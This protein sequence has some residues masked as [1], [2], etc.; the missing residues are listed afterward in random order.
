MEF[1][2]VHIEVI[3][4]VAVLK[5]FDPPANTLTYDLVQQL[6][7]AY[8]EILHQPQVNAVL[9]TGYGDRFFSGGVNIPMLLDASPHF[10]SN[11][12]LYASEVFELF[13]G[14]PLPV[15]AAINGHA[16]GGGL[17]VALSA[18]R[19]VAIE[20]EYNL[21]FPEVRLGVIPGLGGTS[22]L[23]A[24]VGSARALRMIT[25]GEFISSREA[26]SY[27]LVNELFPREG[28]LEAAV[29]YTNGAVDSRLAESRNPGP[30]PQCPD[31]L[32]DYVALEVEGGLARITLK[33]AL[34]GGRAMDALCALNQQ[35]VTARADETVEALL[36]THEGDTLPLS[37]G[38][39][40]AERDYADFVFRR[41][42]SWPRLCALQ[43]NGKL[44]PLAMELALAC[45]YRAC[46]DSEIERPV[47]DGVAIHSSRLR[48]QAPLQINGL[49]L[50]Q[51][52][53]KGFLDLCG[54]DETEGFLCTRVPPEGASTAI[55]YAKLSVGQNASDA[56]ALHLMLE[57]YL[58]ENIFKGPDSKEGMTAY[59][60]K[61]QPSFVGR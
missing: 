42:E 37:F 49:S 44:S 15:V 57:R 54:L 26:L 45:D 28:F 60:E 8:F 34:R 59:M 21:G 23:G 5:L 20:G 50:A 1:R 10:K 33:N 4:G 29:A 6:E 36:I 13:R 2:F 25:K 9:I 38:S 56:S 58:Q 48:R 40:S 19:R 14:C 3:E 7:T 22:R 17:E 11:F 39:D 35:V 46:S 51:A 55:G 18:S 53:E 12:L 32:E 43:F 52:S 31:P 24:I 30:G 47:V 61:R 41:L 27:G 16:T